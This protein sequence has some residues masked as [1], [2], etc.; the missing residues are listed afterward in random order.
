MIANGRSSTWPRLR[1]DRQAGAGALFATASIIDDD[2]AIALP[3]GT[4]TV[5]TGS[6]TDDAVSTWLGRPVTLRRATTDRAATYEIAADFEAE[7]SS[8]LFHWFGPEGTFHDSARTRVS[9]VA[10]GDMRDWAPRRFRMNL[11][12]SGAGS[13]EFIGCTVA[14]GSVVLEVVK[15]VDR[16][17]LTTR[18]Q[19]GGS[20]ATST[21]CAR[22]TGR[23]PASSASARWCSPPAA[24]PWATSC[25]WSC[26]PPQPILR[27]P[28]DADS[29]VLAVTGSSRS[30]SPGRPTPRPDCRDD[31]DLRR[32]AAHAR[33]RPS[34]RRSPSRSATSP[35][36]GCTTRRRCSSTS[37]CTWRCAPR[38]RRPSASVQRC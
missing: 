10:L 27:S 7:D 5:G 37:G 17:V 13:A 22:S 32:P 4:G 35:G 38:Q 29:R 11:L 18:P 21:C 19:P 16:C 31:L 24:S 15:P 3:D 25:G 12:T 33:R 1:A 36:S 6:V 26:A 14:I 34:W 28:S 20:G 2:V 30:D 8:E 23:W 9:I